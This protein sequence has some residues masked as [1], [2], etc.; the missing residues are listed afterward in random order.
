MKEIDYVEE[1]DYMDDGSKVIIYYIIKLSK[2]NLYSVNFYIHY[3][4]F[5]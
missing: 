4:L 5:I 1:E 2:N 3:Y